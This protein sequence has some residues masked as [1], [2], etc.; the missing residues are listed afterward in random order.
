MDNSTRQSIIELILKL[1]PSLSIILLNQ[2][3]YATLMCLENDLVDRNKIYPK[4]YTFKC[5]CRSGS[6]DCGPWHSE[7]CEMNTPF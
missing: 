5:S 1:E 4:E 2:L 3:N 6:K 7:N